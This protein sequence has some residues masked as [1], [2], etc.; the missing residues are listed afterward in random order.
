MSALR[1]SQSFLI[2]HLEDEVIIHRM[3]FVRLYRVCRARECSGFYIPSGRVQSE[4]TSHA[5][6]KWGG[7][8]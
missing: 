3:S 5:T 6:Q 1:D 8:R 2:R 4:P 7:A